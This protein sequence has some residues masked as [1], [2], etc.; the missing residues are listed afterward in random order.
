VATE[1]LYID[2]DGN[3][4]SPEELGAYDVVDVREFD[5]GST[6]DAVKSIPCV[7][8]LVLLIIFREDFKR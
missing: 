3:P 2:E 6:W 7:V 1:E 5:S 8:L 4:V